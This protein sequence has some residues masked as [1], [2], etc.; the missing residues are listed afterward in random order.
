MGGACTR[1]K[2]ARSN[3]AH[4]LDPHAMLLPPWSL[5]A[6]TGLF[7]LGLLY[8]VSWTYL[9]RAVCRHLLGGRRQ[10]DVVISVCTSSKSTQNGVIENSS[11]GEGSS[12]LNS[13]RPLTVSQAPQFDS[14]TDGSPCGGL[15]DDGVLAEIAQLYV[16][17]LYSDTSRHSNI[18]CQPGGH[19]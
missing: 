17:V 12:S 11:K 10:R 6:T 13:R 15:V 14:R 2:R 3:F 5:L 4:I 19:L 16:S 9:A 7:I 18:A 1:H 8:Y